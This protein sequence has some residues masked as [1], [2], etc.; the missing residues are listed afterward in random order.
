MV[1]SDSLFFALRRHFT[2]LSGF[3]VGSICG[4]QDLV[5]V[6][7]LLLPL[8][9]GESSESVGDPGLV[10]QRRTIRGRLAILEHGGGL[11]EDEVDAEATETR[12]HKPSDARAGGRASQGAHESDEKRCRPK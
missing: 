3:A 9:Q 8:R 6:E 1:L 7:D 11:H 5:L 2:L 12:R 4:G 10:F